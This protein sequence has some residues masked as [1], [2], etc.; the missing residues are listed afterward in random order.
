MT[1]RDL[2]VKH[3][4][5]IAEIVVYARRMSNEEYEQWK[6]ETLE[7]AKRNG[8]QGFISKVFIVIDKYRR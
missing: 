3:I 1:E 7:F 5:E 2:Y 4:P 8:A 6:Q